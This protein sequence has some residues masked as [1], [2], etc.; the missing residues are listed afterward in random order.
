MVPIYFELTIV[1]MH[2]TQSVVISVRSFNSLMTF[3][4]FGDCKPDDLTATN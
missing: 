1:V 4:S 3:D 2:A